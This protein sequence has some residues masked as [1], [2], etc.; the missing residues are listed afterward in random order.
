MV[1]RRALLLLF[2][3]ALPLSAQTPASP[4][5]QPTGSVLRWWEGAAVFGGVAVATLFDEGVQHSLQQARSQSSDDVAAI[6][7]RI[8]QPEVFATIPAALFLTGILSRRQPLRHAATRIAASLAVTGVLVTATKF[9]VGR[10]RPTQG[11]EPDV[12]RPFSGSDAFPSG[13]AAMAFTL[14]TSLADEIRRPWATVVL[15]AAAAGTGWSRLNDNMHWL[16]DVVAGAALGI[17]SAQVIE[18]RWRFRRFRVVPL[19][20]GVALRVAL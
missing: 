11:E 12:L 15:M 17:A 6:V 5:P 19:R 16:S 8:G 4:Q 7:R 14:A 1:V 10:Q 9:I 20:S 3:L 18:R 13:H 2:G